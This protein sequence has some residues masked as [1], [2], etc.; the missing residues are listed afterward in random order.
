MRDS[1]FNMPIT[2]MTAEERVLELCPDG[3]GV[4]E[5]IVI[6]GI[7]EA[8]GSPANNVEVVI[9]RT[10]PGQELV[11][12]AEGIRTGSNGVFTWCKL[13]RGMH[14]VISAS[15]DGVKRTVEVPNL[16]RGLTV[17]RF[18]LKEER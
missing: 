8:D 5:S 18:K 3:K 12:M 16:E 7:L 10:E 15:R 9:D 17:L 2:T 14:V 4:G 6:G 13:A 11:R 1:V